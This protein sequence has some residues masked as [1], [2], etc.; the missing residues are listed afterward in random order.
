MTQRQFVLVVVDRDTGEFTIEGP[1]SD[2]RPW[3]SAVGDKQLFDFY[4]SAFLGAGRTVDCRLRHEHRAIYALWRVQGNSRLTPDEDRLMK[5]L[6]DDRDYEIHESGL[7]RVV[8][9]ECVEFYVGKHRQ[10]VNQ[11]SGPPGMPPI[12]L[13]PT[14]T[15]NVDG[16]DRT[17]TDAC[18]EYLAL[19]KR[20]VIDFA[21]EHPCGC[22]GTS[23]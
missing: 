22:A 4:L 6:V 8:G 16:A 11:V 1:M 3:N 10:G 2:D 21:T 14:Y 9:E 12:V 5:C 7:N 17:V 23:R 18:G 19:L 20:L 13:R 15:F